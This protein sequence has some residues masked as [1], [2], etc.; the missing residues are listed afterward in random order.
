MAR[1]QNQ[2]RDAAGPKRLLLITFDF[3]PRRTSGI[4]RPSAFTKY[5]ARHGWIPTILTVQV[6]ETDLQDP[7]LLKKIPPQVELVRTKYLDITSWENPSAG[8][9]RNLGGLAPQAGANHASSLDRCLRSIAEFIRSC[10]YFPD[11]T[12]GWVPFG[13]AKAI[14]LIRQRRFDA[15]YSSSPP[16]S[17][18]VIG[19]LLKFL[20]GLPWIAEFRDPW[21]PPERRVRR[22]MEKHLLRLIGRKADAIVV[23]TS[24]HAKELQ[25]SGFG[26][27]AEKISVVTNGF[28]EED[29][30]SRP[31][32]ANN[33]LMP[34]GYIH[35]THLGTVYPSCSG[36]FFE[37]LKELVRECPDVKQKLRVNVIGYP[38]DVVQRYASDE[39]LRSLV[40]LHGFVDHNQSLDVIRSS[41]CLLLFWANH[42]YAREAVAGK[43]Y[44][45]L[46]TGRPIFAITYDGPMKTLIE[47]ARAGWVAQPDDIA[48]MK[49]ILAKI[50][51]TNGSRPAPDPARAE[52]VAQFQYERLAGKML[53]IFEKVVNHGG[54]T[55]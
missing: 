4:Y 17:S 9:V 27:E 1:T 38:D 40:N 21:Y 33:T 5:F 13:L 3:P 49:Q 39:S 55:S 31:I 42:D 18:V 26:I 16:R 52:F 20:F 51:S 53:T 48:A 15:I 24:G 43:T 28:D 2:Q 10:V 36:K 47:G 23:V 32:S 46:R 29:F 54:Q 41:D 7:A 35:L 11:N 22:F 8:A 34:P 12:V 37:A 44:E 30:V 19:L 6:R 50:V 45:Y 14:Q 25:S